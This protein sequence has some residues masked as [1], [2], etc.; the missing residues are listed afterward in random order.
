MTTMSIE[1][2]VEFR[3]KGHGGR[4]ELRE[5]ETPRPAKTVAIALIQTNRTGRRPGGEAA[6]KS[7]TAPRPEVCIQPIGMRSRTRLDGLLFL[8]VGVVG[9]QHRNQR[10]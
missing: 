6:S 8:D 7:G 1:R 4:K 3:R 9:F 10:P 5:R 2:T